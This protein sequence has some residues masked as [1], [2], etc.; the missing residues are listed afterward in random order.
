VKHCTNFQERRDYDDIDMFATSCI[1]GHTCNLRTYTCDYWIMQHT[2]VQKEI[3]KHID[4]IHGRQL[5]CV[6]VWGVENRTQ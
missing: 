6:M 3:E 2:N 1:K 5:L 4:I